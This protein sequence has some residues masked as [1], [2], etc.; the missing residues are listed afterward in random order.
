MGFTLTS[1][2]QGY[3]AFMRETAHAL[4]NA[5]TNYTEELTIL[6]PDITREKK[7]ANFVVVYPSSLA[8]NLTTNLYASWD[9]GTTKVLMAAIKSASST[10]GTYTAQIDLNQYPAPKYYIGFVAVG[11]ESSRTAEI[12]VHA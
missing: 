3:Q 12:I 9:G 2:D 6:Q 10:A 8:G 5:T 7:Y 4:P 11:N 1:V